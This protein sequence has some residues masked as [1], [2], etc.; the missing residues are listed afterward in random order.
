MLHS[1]NMHVTLITC[2]LIIFIFNCREHDKKGPGTQ[3]AECIHQISFSTALKTPEKSE[4]LL[5]LCTGLKK[6]HLYKP[7]TMCPY[8]SLIWGKL[9]P[10][11]FFNF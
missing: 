11:V 6:Y 1:L 7:C 9:V 8:I 10:M 4:C 2:T 3:D 5:L